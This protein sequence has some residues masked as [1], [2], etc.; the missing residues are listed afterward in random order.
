MWAR[1]DAGFST[2]LRFAR[3][4]RALRLWDGVEAVLGEIAP[5]LRASAASRGRRVRR[6]D[7]AMPS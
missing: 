6:R 5:G 7:G 3:N 4:D 2:P 1:A